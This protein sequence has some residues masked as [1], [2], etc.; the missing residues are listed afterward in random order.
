MANLYNLEKDTLRH[1]FLLKPLVDHPLASDKA[2]DSIKQ[3]LL[4]LP[5]YKGLILSDDDRAT[6]MAITFDGKIINT[7]ARVPIIKF[8]HSKRGCEV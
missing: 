3:T 8:R 1:R 5:F 2:V 6:L 4:S 7:P